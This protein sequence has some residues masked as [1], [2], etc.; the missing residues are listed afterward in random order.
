MPLLFF[1][2]LECADGVPRH[3][4]FYVVRDANLY[5]IVPETHDRTV[6]SAVRY[7]FVAHLQVV[8]HLLQLLLA[9]RIGTNQDEIK[10]NENDKK[11]EET[12]YRTR[13]GGL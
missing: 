12:D 2:I 3:F 10:D 11:R 6:D 7:D 4:D 9:R 1:R 8:N 13:L 5:P